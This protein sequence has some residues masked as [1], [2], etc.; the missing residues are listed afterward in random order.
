MMR[1]QSTQTH[2]I[3]LHRLAMFPSSCAIGQGHDSIGE[4]TLRGDP[5]LCIGD[6]M[7]QPG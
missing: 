4:I 3:A 1:S 7:A 5:A 2:T 6:K